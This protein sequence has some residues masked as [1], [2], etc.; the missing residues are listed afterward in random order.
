M[1]VTHVC[2]FE[3]IIPTQCSQIPIPWCVR[4]YTFNPDVWLPHACLSTIQTH[5]SITHIH[6]TQTHI[7]RSYITADRCLHR[8]QTSSRY[9]MFP[10]EK[11]RYQPKHVSAVSDSLSSLRLCLS[12]W[13]VSGLSPSFC[14][15]S[16][17]Q[18]PGKTKTLLKIVFFYYLFLFTITFS[19]F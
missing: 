4:V 18:F 8:W 13:S 12:P 19:Y 3:S 7:K 2:V 5:T 10:P 16:W 15:I 9:A 11:I 14:F 6:C 17:S 1:L